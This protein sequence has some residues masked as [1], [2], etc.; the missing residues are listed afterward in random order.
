MS[1]IAHREQ[2]YATVP[3]ARLPLLV[4]ARTLASTRT[5]PFRPLPPLLLPC[6][7]RRRV[8]I[9]RPPAL[10]VPHRAGDPGHLIGLTPLSV[11]AADMASA[12]TV[13]SNAGMCA[14][15]AIGTAAVL[16]AAL[17]ALCARVRAAVATTTAGDHQAPLCRPWAPLL[18]R[19]GALHSPPSTLKGALGARL[20]VLLPA[21]RVCRRIHLFAAACTVLAALHACRGF[22]RRVLPQARQE[23]RP[24]SGAA[25]TTTT[26]AARRASRGAHH[27]A[28]HGATGAR[29]GATAGTAR[30]PCPAVRRAPLR[31]GGGL[32]PARRGAKTKSHP[33]RF[34][35]RRLCAG[36][37]HPT[38]AGRPRRL[39]TGS[40]PTASGGRQPVRGRRATR[41]SGRWTR[42]CPAT[43]R[44]GSCGSLRSTC[45]G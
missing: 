24:T 25:A 27:R 22:R 1:P 26:R 2:R 15:A 39:A 4:P 8:G 41:R 21:R 33:G 37:R 19:Q 36:M 13:S 42:L 14:T 23:V 18:G 32:H 45:W 6:R 5:C 38:G 20:P 12:T 11:A 35:G 28:R 9:A 3:G 7:T 34:H 44:R 29:Q 43:T 17:P 10:V 16:A 30:G 31:V 40:A